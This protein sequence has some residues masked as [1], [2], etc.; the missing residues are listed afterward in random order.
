MSHLTADGRPY[1]RERLIAEVRYHLGTAVL[2]A[3][4][5]LIEIKEH[6]EHGSWISTLDELGIHRRTASRMMQAARRFL[7]GPNKLLSE[8]LGGAY[9]L[10]ELA[11]WDDE[12]LQEL[13]EGA[14]V[15]GVVLDELETMSVSELRARIRADREERDARDAAQRERIALK[16]REI[17]DLGS[18]VKALDRQIEDLRRPGQVRL[19][20]D[21][22]VLAAQA[23][24][25]RLEHAALAASMEAALTRLRL[26]VVPH[27]PKAARLILEEMRRS[28]LE[29]GQYLR[30]IEDLVSEPMVPA[31]AE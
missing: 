24:T 18:E 26:E 27:A 1:D 13:Q 14:T 8:H 7:A 31:D 15:R 2:E 19:T 3:G 22:R 29:A 17:E 28:V 4:R 20:E 6:E 12:E 11:T 23:S 5:R 25:F 9:K 16:E 10:Y 21:Q 30:R